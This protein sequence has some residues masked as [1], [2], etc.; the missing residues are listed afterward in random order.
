MFARHVSG[1]LAAHLD[2]ALAHPKAEQVERHLRACRR[3]QAERE[4]VREGMAIL[5]QLPVAHAP[6]AVWLSIETALP[7]PRSAQTP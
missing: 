5:E 6:E 7:E 2:G 4:E 3:C 1:Q